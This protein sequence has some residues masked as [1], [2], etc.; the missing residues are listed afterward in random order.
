[1]TPIRVLLADDEPLVRSGLRAI[2]ESEPEDRKS[3]V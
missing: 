3:G 1:M 2:L